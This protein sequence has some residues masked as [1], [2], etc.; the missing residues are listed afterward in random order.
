MH[1]D[2]RRFIFATSI[3]LSLF[4]FIS[5]NLSK[6]SAATFYVS[7]STSSVSPSGKF[8]VTI[9][10][11]EAGSGVFYLQGNNASVPSSVFCD[12]SCV[13]Q[14]TAGSSGTASIT[15]T[16][17]APNSKDEVTTSNGSS[18]ITGS[19]T[20]SV[21]IVSNSGGNSG[22]NNGNN[23]SSNN[24]NSGSGNNNPATPPVKDEQDDKSSE[25]ML[26]SLT[27]SKGKLSPE[28]DE[29]ITS[30][31]L[32]LTN[33]IASIDVN[34]KAKDAKAAVSGIGK[35]DLKAGKTDINI[36]VTAE[37]GST[38]TYT[39]HVTVEE[40]SKEFIKYNGQKLGILTNLDEVTP[41]SGF[42]K[43]KVKVSGKERDG[44]YNAASK[45]YLIYLADKDMVKNFYMV[46]NQQVTSIY[47]PIQLLGKSLV[48]IDVPDV[49][50]KKNGMKF[51]TITIDNQ[52]L[53]GWTFKDKNFQNYYL[54]YVM[55]TKGN[56]KYYQYEKTE[57]TLQLY[58]G[59]AP[60]T[61]H[62]YE[63]EKANSGNSWLIYA[64]LGSSAVLLAALIYTY[65]RNKK[66][67]AY[68]MT[69]RRLNYRN[70]DNESL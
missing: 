56:V 61:A 1:I 26:S 38:R 44:W 37:N 9:S 19:R 6:I 67:V 13:V 70:E 23:N 58:S 5:F 24:N 45:I 63:K 68:L 69:Q 48:M 52:K 50:Q 22:G 14:A 62:D 43:T 41:P 28:F 10:L 20:I 32:N 17:G 46:E 34:A 21:S 7:S 25:S 49:L 3:F 8:N 60:I 12:G 16:A 54:I 59:A 66:N 36:T 64:G 42:E 53:K 47:K 29:N 65:L 2:K 39:I 55:D 30:Y 18:Y 11:S 15:V 35:H 33:D 40:K 4:C 31:N 51:T 27:V 57:E